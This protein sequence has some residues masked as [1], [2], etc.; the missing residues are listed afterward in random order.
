MGALR[1][2]GQGANL[3]ATHLPTPHAMSNTEGRSPGSTS[4][5]SLEGIDLLLPLLKEATEGEY[6]IE[7]E[8]GRGGMAAVYLARDVALNRRVAIKTML[9][10]LIGRASMVDR[11]KREAQMAAGLSHPHII[12]IHTVRSTPRLVYFV[13]KCIEGRSVDSILAERGA[14]DLETTR[15]I[16]QQAASALSFAHHRGIIHRDIKPG[17]IMIDENG[18]A[19]V[20]DFGI[21]KLEDAQNL[22]ATGHTL[23]TPHYMSPEQFHNKPLTGASDQ[24]ALGIVA[25][26]MLTGRKPFDGG[27]FAEI[28]TKQLFSPPPDIRE[29]RPDLPDTVADTITR[30]LAKETGDR[31]P[32]LESAIAAFGHPAPATLDMVRTQLMAIARSSEQR[33]PRLSVP[34]SPVSS[35][36]PSAQATMLTPVPKTPVPKTPVPARTPIAG[37]SETPSV[38]RKR[39]PAWIWVTAVLLVLAVPGF[40]IGS[41]YIPANSG[42]QNASMERGIRLWQQRSPAAAESEFVRAAREMPNSALPHV[43]LSRLARERGNLELARTEGATAVRLEPGNA[44][45]LREMGMVLLALQN[46]DAS[47]RF[48]ARALRANPADKAAMGWL[49]CSLQKMGQVDQAERWRQRAGTGPWMSC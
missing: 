1:L 34:M 16:V 31:F 30:M 18:W 32:D 29:D 26:E 8:L 35:T 6:E 14:L 17:N 47:R 13:M 48:F 5:P 15:L 43:Y 46:Y 42:S 44:I 9:P 7:R 38:P 2:H 37:A 49:S 45:A 36:R 27:T 21:A 4:E 11:F 41:R 40:I 3:H 33:K 20:T 25:Y 19:V 23:G 28:V 24:Y 12:Q 10:E 22:T 39:V